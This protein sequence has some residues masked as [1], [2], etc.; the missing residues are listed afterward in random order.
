MNIEQALEKFKVDICSRTTEI[1]PTEEQD[2][3][4]LSLGYF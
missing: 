2:L 1:D 3:Y 4:S